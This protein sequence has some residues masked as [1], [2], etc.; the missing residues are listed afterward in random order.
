[1]HPYLSQAIAAE[2][3]A[4]ALRAA[5]A[6]RRARDAGGLVA[7]DAGAADGGLRVRGQ[8]FGGGGQRRRRWRRLGISADEMVK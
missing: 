7:H 4:D 1:M 5:D 3:R 8:W 2:R 6:S